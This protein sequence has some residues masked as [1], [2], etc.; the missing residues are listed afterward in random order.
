MVE[1]LYVMNI[2]IPE[3]TLRDWINNN[4]KFVNLPLKKLSLN[5]LYKGG[6]VKYADINNKFIDYIE[7]NRKMGFAV[8]T[9]PL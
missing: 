5:A 4:D 2:I 8:T 1:F 7:F 3:S 9:W 6:Q